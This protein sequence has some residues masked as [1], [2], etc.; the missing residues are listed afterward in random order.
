MDAGVAEEV[1]DDGSDLD[2]ELDEEGLGPEGGSRRTQK[3]TEPHRPS[4]EE[5]AEHE[6]THLPYR[7]WCRHC[8]IGRGLEMPHVRSKRIARG[9]L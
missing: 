7:N 3:M 6:M 5:V 2:G 9:S 4:S 1:V 8:V